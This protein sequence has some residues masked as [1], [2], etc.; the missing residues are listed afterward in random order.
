MPSATHRVVAKGNAGEAVVRD[1]LDRATLLAR[2]GRAAARYQWR[3]LAYCLMDT[4]FHLVLETPEP[5]LSRGMQWLCG[6]YAQ[7]FNTR[8]GR[9]GDLFGGRFYSG[10][11]RSDAHLIAAIAYVLAN[12]LRAGICQRAEERTWSSFAATAGQ[13]PCPPFLEAR[14][15]LELFAAQPALARLRLAEIVALSAR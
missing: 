8:H 14:R 6:R 12:P 5:T 9:S 7:D 10:L 15:V 1:D 11:I 13:E 4:H 3:C 2:L